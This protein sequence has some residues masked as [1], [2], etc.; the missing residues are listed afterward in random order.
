MKNTVLT[1]Q[2]CSNFY[3]PHISYGQVRTFLRNTSMFVYDRVGYVLN[4]VVARFVDEDEGRELNLSFRGKDYPTNVL[5]FGYQESGH[6]NA[7]IILCVPVVW[8]ESILQGKVLHHHYAHL[9]V[10]GFLHAYGFDH[11]EDHE[12]K[13]MEDLE[14]K[15]LHQMSFP[16]PY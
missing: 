2:W 11:E 14:R 3:P 16:D 9:L 8:K 15:V 7:D 13:I 4:V 10:H 1:Y 12:A 5:T 6:Y